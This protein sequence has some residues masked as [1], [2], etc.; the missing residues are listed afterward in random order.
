M[1]DVGN[2]LGQIT[3]LMTIMIRVV[4]LIGGYFWFLREFLGFPYFLESAHVTI[5]DP[6][7]LHVETSKDLPISNSEI[8]LAAR[9]VL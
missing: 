1:L 2:L 6:R 4:G 3:Y 9:G 7:W 5:Y 8:S